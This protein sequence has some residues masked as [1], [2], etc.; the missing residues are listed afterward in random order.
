MLNLK[1]ISKLAKR[2]YLSKKSKDGFTLVEVIVAVVIL[3][4]LTTSLAFGFNSMI[5]VNRL[6]WKKLEAVN[7]VNDIKSACYRMSYD[8]LKDENTAKFA[9]EL[10]SKIQNGDG[11]VTTSSYSSD[12]TTIGIKDIYTA[13]NKYDVDLEFELEDNS[14]N[15]F[16]DS[17]YNS[18][19]SDNTCVIDIR[20]PWLEFDDS[21]DEE[22]G[23]T[24]TDTGSP[25]IQFLEELKLRNAEYNAGVEDKK[26]LSSYFTDSELLQLGD[27]ELSVTISSDDVDTYTV[28]ALYYYHLRNADRIKLTKD[29]DCILSSLDDFSVSIKDSIKF[30][31]IKDIFVIF[32]KDITVNVVSNIVNNTSL[33]IQLYVVGA[34]SYKSNTS[35]SVDLPVTYVGNNIGGSWNLSAKTNIRN[36]LLNSLGTEQNLWGKSASYN[37]EFRL[38]IKVQDVDRVYEDTSVV[39]GV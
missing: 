9:Q 8:E 27:R 36:L 15:T 2:V 4:M 35:G 30:T 7:I 13:N 28:N 25:D 3:S 22:T 20:K 5:K 1:L 19:A 18:L 26:L 31:D 33:D 10:A 6:S 16:Q 39:I 17:D 32:N 37:R 24:Y 29:G 23:Y 11:V 38:H 34:E 21:Y 14:I 12:V